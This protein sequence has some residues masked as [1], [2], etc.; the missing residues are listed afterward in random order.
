MEIVVITKNLLAILIA[1]AAS[2]SSMAAQPLSPDTL[3]ETERAKSVGPNMKGAAVLRA[4]VLLDR[5]HFSSGEIDAAYGP[6]MRKAIDGYQKASGLKVTGMIDAPTWAALNA[7]TAP[8]LTS[9]T[10]LDTDVAGPFEP[11]PKEMAD[12]AKMA[13]LGYES[14]AEAMGEKFHVNPKLLTLLNPGKDL[15][16]A[17]EE[18]V[19][20]NITA[21]IELPKAA[22]VIIT[23]SDGT[24]TLVDASGKTIAQFPATTG[25]KHDPLP[26]GNWKV[27]GI[28][29]NPVSHYNPKLFWDADPGDTK[30]TIPAGP[31]NP[32]GVVWVDLSKEHYGIHGTP[33]P[34]RIGKTQSHGCIRLTNW[35]AAAVAQSVAVGVDV[36]MQ[37]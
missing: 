8:I 30:A 36:L 27:R 9:Y 18:I 10:V 7:D 21:A 24:L 23:R 28:A 29:R 5:A 1:C 16:R 22:K 17:G 31:N 2:A 6:N 13:A 20:P 12:K 35:D 11:I 19:A 33:E 37:E 25:S 14:A 26:L 4:Q 3:S 32:V 15:A 34:S